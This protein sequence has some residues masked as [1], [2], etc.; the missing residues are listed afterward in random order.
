MGL[1]LCHE[2]VRHKDKSEIRRITA[3]SAMKFEGY[4]CIYTCTH[5]HTH[6]GTQVCHKMH[7]PCQAACPLDPYVPIPMQIE[8]PAP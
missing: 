8:S 2:V 4:Y 7:V 1:L 3:E 5:T 6:R